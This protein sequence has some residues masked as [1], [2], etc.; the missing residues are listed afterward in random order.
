MP[1]SR[2]YLVLAMLVACLSSVRPAAG[3]D[4]GQAV[5]AITLS[6]FGG[7][8]GGGRITTILASGEV[9]RY[10]CVGPN[11][12]RCAA[13]ESLGR[14]GAAFTRWSE[15]LAAAHFAEL[16]LHG[17]FGDG[18]CALATKQGGSVHATEFSG[19]PENPGG[20]P[21]AVARVIRELGAWHNRR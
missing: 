5:D 21:S 16:Q 6:C 12:N 14:D 17:G 13:P 15:A 19:L 18:A 20:V 1:R 4:A 11:E 10:D 8:T 2:H 9:Q 7:I 3:D